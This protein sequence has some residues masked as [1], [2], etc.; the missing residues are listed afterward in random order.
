[1]IKKVKITFLLV[2]LKGEI[3]E[4]LYK[5]NCKKKANQKEFRVKVIKI[6]GN[7]LYVK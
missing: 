4:T 2:I 1:M 6:K 3:F 5:Q 7:K